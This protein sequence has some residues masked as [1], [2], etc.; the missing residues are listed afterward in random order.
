MSNFQAGSQM[1]IHFPENLVVPTYFTNIVQTQILEDEVYLNFCLRSME[2]PLLRADLQCR[3]ITTLA[4][5]RRLN[6]G[7]SQLLA[8]HEQAR[9]QAQAQS[10]QAPQP[11]PTPQGIAAGAAA[12]QAKHGR[13]DASA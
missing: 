12:Q 8:Q 2:K 7:L 5:L 10:A 11:A 1:D 4:S 6:Q 13:R 9:A 3:I